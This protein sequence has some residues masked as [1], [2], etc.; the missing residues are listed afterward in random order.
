MI[1]SQIRSDPW[2]AVMCYQVI[3]EALDDPFRVQERFEKRI[4]D[5][6]FDTTRVQLVG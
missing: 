1:T 4:I 6:V 2:V 3:L 5:T